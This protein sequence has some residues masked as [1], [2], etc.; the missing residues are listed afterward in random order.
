M[1]IGS[2]FKQTP[3]AVKGIK[4]GRKSALDAD[5]NRDLEGDLQ[6][7]VHLA[8][9]LST[10]DKTQPFDRVSRPS[11]LGSVRNSSVKPATAS[12]VL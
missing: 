7:A 2:G 10:Q 12:R 11:V 5:L 3:I 9:D 6:N 4:N 8:I 1:M